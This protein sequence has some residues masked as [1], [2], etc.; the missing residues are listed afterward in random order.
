MGR[1]SALIAILTLVALSCQAAEPAPGG[2]P[3]TAPTATSITGF[4]PITPVAGQAAAGPTSGGPLTLPPPGQAPL[5][6]GPVD[7]RF[8]VALSR[9]EYHQHTLQTIGV[10]WYL[11]YGYNTAD[12]PGGYHK[13]LKLPSSRLVNAAELAGAVK[14]SP[15]SYWAIGNEPNTPGQDDVAPAD[16]AER[17]HTYAQVI[18]QADPS[19]RLVGPEVL[20]F[21]FTC[22]GCPGFTSGRQFVDE[23]RTAYHARYNSEPPFDV[24][25]IHTYD[26][27]WQQLPQGDW[28]LQTQQVAAYRD[29]LN[30][31]PALRDKPIWLTEFAVVWGYDG[32]AWDQTGQ[33][34]S[35]RPDG[36]YHSDHLKAYLQQMTAWLKANAGPMRIERWFLF[37]S[38]GY[39]EPWATT[40]A[41]IILLN[42]LGPDAQLTEL[43]WLYRT[44]AAAGP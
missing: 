3:G 7:D 43:G 2:N 13:L 1:W 10:P 34:V 44:L 14:A 28:Q 25:S 42:R 29:Y 38:H 26:L 19:A 36:A 32:I 35:A 4:A 41:G 27:N 9:A 23:L 22:N 24:W 8:G 30:Q 31:Q 20:N 12:I 33:Q 18:K 5:P 40:A 21:D 17:L 15:G 37:S 39:K 11:D 16:Y 6:A